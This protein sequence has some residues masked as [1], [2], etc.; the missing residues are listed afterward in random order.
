MTSQWLLYALPASLAFVAGAF[1]TYRGYR[2]RSRIAK[3]CG[4]ALLVC[5]LAWLLVGPWPS[6]WTRH[7]TNDGAC[8]IEFP[9]PPQRDTTATAGDTDRLEVS[10]ADRNITYSLAYSDV[11]DESAAIPLDERFQLLREHYASKRTPGDA[12]TKLLKEQT[13]RERG[14][15]G[16][17]YHFAVGNTLVTRI[18]VFIRGSRIYRAIVVYPPDATLDRDAQRFLDSFRF[19]RE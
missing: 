4:P 15:E 11:S 3:W 18:K 9:Q 13:I 6:G 19:M 7:T 17:E 16:R 2:G 12:P 5:A 10:F 1:A 8:S 14:T